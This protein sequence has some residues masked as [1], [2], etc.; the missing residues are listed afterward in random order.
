MDFLKKDKLRILLTG[1]RGF[2]ARKVE[3]RLKNLGHMVIGFDIQD[4]FDLLNR[5]QVGIAVA[6]VDAVY[7][8]AAEADMTRM[9]DLPG[10]YK[11]TVVN[12]DGTHNVAY[13][14]AKH[15]K[16]LIYT[17]TCCVY[18]NATEHPENEDSTLPNPSELYAC[19][20][21]AGEWIVRGYGLNYDMPWT[22][23]RY[24]TIYG[25]G[26][27]EALGVYVFFKQAMTGQP[28]TVHGDGKQER[29]LTFV[30]DLVEGT[31]APLTHKEQAIGE[32]FN[33]SATER[34]SAIKM[35]EDIK[36]L[37]QSPSE[38]TFIPQ[39]KN[40]TILEDVDASKAEKLLGWKA[41]TP[42]NTGLAAT[43]EWMRSR[44]LR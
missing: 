21:Y 35:A 9:V 22:I 7:H 13:A 16:W 20:K 3:K 23:L 33:L 30:D 34:I 43:H 39:R 2:I 25:E 38:I 11:G 41:A 28:I 44:D 4:G 19:S 32:I 26:M 40:Q 1:N 15:Q 31:V 36:K 10:S 27:R 18:G 17:S 12:V 8:I 42:W 5:E 6:D 37:T 24:A 14:C 29:T